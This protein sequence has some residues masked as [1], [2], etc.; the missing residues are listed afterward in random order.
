MLADFYQ[1]C[2]ISVAIILNLK[3]TQML[4]LDYLVLFNSL[5]LNESNETNAWDRD[6]EKDQVLET[7]I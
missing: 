3:L 2:A 1:S 7:K 5:M 6:W 4:S